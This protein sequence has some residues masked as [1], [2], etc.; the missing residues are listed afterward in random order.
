MD[1]GIRNKTALVLGGGGGLGRAISKAL[2]DEG[3]N[4]AVADIDE[5]AIEGTRSTLAGEKS[6][7]LVW[8]LARLDQI[9]PAFRESKRNLERSIS[10]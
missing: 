3:A 9:D 7:G 8:D 10:S 1:L 5:K 6:M 4:V 2:A